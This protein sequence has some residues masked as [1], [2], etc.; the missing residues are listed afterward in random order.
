MK[1]V[2]LVGFFLSLNVFGIF[3]FNSLSLWKKSWEFNDSDYHRKEAL[4]NSFKIAYQNWVDKA[5]SQGKNVLHYTIDLL[6]GAS[7]NVE[8]DFLISSIKYIL[9]RDENL[10][11]EKID[12]KPPVFY[13]LEK[14][15]EKP[16]INDLI[17]SFLEQE[18]DPDS[19][20]DLG[21][22]LLHYAVFSENLELCTVLVKQYKANLNAATLDKKIT[23]L[24]IA[25]A[26][27]AV[28]IFDLLMNN[29]ARAGICTVS[30]AN[31]LHF[32]A[33]RVLLMKT[34]SH[35]FASDSFG[36]FFQQKD[37]ELYEKQLHFRN[38]MAERLIME[39]GLGCVQ[40][41]S[42]G[43]TAFDYAEKFG[44]DLLADTM[45]RLCKEIRLLP[46]NSNKKIQEEKFSAE[47]KADL[48][49]EFD[50]WIDCAKAEN[51]PVLKCIF[52]IFENCAD[53]AQFDFACEGLEYILKKHPDTI[54]ELIENKAPL[55]YVIEK[56]SKAFWLRSVVEILLKS[57][58]DQNSCDSNDWSIL[59]LAIKIDNYE[60]FKTIANE[61]ADL[62]VY[63]KKEKIS[64]LH[65]ACFY[66]NKEIFDF[67]LDHKVNFAFADSNNDT[68][69]HFVTGCGFYDKDNN[70]NQILP[71]ISKVNAKN[72]K[73]Y[74]EQIVIRKYMINK[75][76]NEIGLPYLVEDK[77]GLTARDYAYAFGHDELLTCLPT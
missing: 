69:F 58:A 57:G 75:L 52:C 16:F 12:N 40:Q 48:N 43:F 73:F 32:A 33:G 61:H 45:R 74:Q 72:Q 13:L 27:G 67:L 64:L 28:E 34:S 35:V 50:H 54:K 76:R 25:C 71:N 22:S 17:K 8:I 66:G 49:S 26:L 2:F 5:K 56:Y 62:M 10:L 39:G 42:F 15:F 6:E 63:T 36:V 44:N 53:L 18:A 70:Y 37:K 41:D 29:Q 55:F 38:H 59:H 9:I 1:K 14:Y 4:K 11:Y 68:A 21:W 20:D 47:I 19:C 24:H 51:I 30:K 31:A 3:A 23:P 7:K 65:L 77:S 46:E 60:L